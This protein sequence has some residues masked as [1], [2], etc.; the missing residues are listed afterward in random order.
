MLLQLVGSQLDNVNQ[1]ADSHI[2]IV[3]DPGVAKT[4]MAHYYL[5]YAPKAIYSSGTNSSKAGLTGACIKDEFT[6]DWA[7][8]AGVLPKSNGGIAVIDELDK[9]SDDDSKVMHDALETQIVPIRK[10]ISVDLMCKCGVLA[11][12][13]PK[14]SSFD[15]TLEVMKQI[16]LPGSLLNRFDLIYILKDKY[17]KKKDTEIA[18][19]IIKS[20]N[21]EEVNFNLPEEKLEKI[22]S[23]NIFIFVE[24]IF[25]LK[26]LKKLM[27]YL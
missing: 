2:L 24:I 25:F 6:G 26:F 12:A 18:Q 27:N 4:K 11:I 21:N 23:E 10:A 3:G 14:Y 22:L 1:R 19:H 15:E 8:E 9:M 7:I 17:N 16:D 20:W 5:E 13:N